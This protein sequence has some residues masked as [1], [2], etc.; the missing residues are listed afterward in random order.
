[1][2]LFELH[3]WGNVHFEICLS[4]SIKFLAPCVN[5]SYALFHNA[6]TSVRSIS[7]FSIWHLM[8]FRISSASRADGPFD[9]VDDKNSSV[10]WF[11]SLAVEYPI[12]NQFTLDMMMV[13]HVVTNCGSNRKFKYLYTNLSEE[14]RMNL[15]WQAALEG[16]YCTKSNSWYIWPPVY[17]ETACFHSKSLLLCA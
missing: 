16:L 6:Q 14:F 11:W 1:M 7:S 5:K 9:P 15:Y 3:I 17:A 10:M 12:L 8:D 4:S 2:S 13:Q